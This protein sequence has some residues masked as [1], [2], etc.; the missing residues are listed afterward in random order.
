[1]KCA[2]GLIMKPQLRGAAALLASL[3][4]R[5]FK[6]YNEI[7]NGAALVSTSHS[8]QITI[9]AKLIHAMQ[10]SVCINP[11]SVCLSPG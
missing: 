9:S 2:A 5:R 6:R 3:T 1:M 11:I 7:I 4:N 10:F 8:C